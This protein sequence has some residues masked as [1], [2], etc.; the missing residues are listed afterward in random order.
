[1]KAKRIIWGVIFAI[2]AAC[3]I[4]VLARIFLMNDND[5]LAEIYP[6]EAAISAYEEGKELITH[7]SFKSIASDG[8]FSANG[9]IYCRE[10]GEL[11][12]TGRYNDSLFTYLDAPENTEFTWKLVDK[13]SGAEYEGKVVESAEKYI[14]NYR[15]LVFEGVEI[16]DDSEIY[17]FLCYGDKYPIEDQ[18]EG[19]LLHIPECKWET[20]E[21][22]DGEIAR[23]TK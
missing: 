7:E 4:L 5:T 3:L 1:M 22:S 8:Y 19:L 13:V 21:L 15:K 20:Y 16:K 6:T 14:Y 12:L 10:T 17:L 11:Q 18:T 9:L 2:C 23:L